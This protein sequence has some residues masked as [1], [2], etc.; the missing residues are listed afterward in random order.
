MD[1]PVSRRLLGATL[2]IIVLLSSSQARANVGRTPGAAAVTHDGE[3]SYSIP[4][5]LPPGTNG[6]TPVISLEY[7]HRTQNGLLGVGWSFGGLSQIARCPRTIVQDGI[8]SPLTLT[9][10]D[11]FC[12]DGQRLVASNGVAYGTAGAEYRTEIESFARIRAIFG[13]G[14]GPQ[15][16]VVESADGRVY[17]Y[18]ATP[19]SR[20]DGNATAIHPTVPARIWAL[21]RIRDRSGNVIDYAYTEEPTHGNF[22]VASI[23]YNSNPAAGAAPSH[24]VSFFYENRPS[25]EIDLGYI[26]GTPIRQVVRL[27]RIDILFNGS[28]LRRYDLSYEP[29]LST[30]GRSRLASIKECGAGGSACFAPTTLVWQNGTA[31][32][33]DVQAFSV[34]IPSPTSY[35]EHKLWNTL[36]I[37][38]DGR[39]DHAW[40]GG[41]TSRSATIRYRLSLAGGTWGPEIDTGILAE[42]GLGL[43]F[44]WN[45]DSRDDLLLI[46]ATRRWAILPG[47]AAGFGAQITTALNVPAQLQD[48]R[49]ADL[50]GDGLGDIAWSEL[51]DYSGNSLV[52]RAQFALPGGGFSVAPETLY[53]QA[54]AIGYEFQQGGSFMGRPGQRID[55]D[56]DGA[57]ELLLDEN[58]TVARISATSFATDFFDGGFSG[59]T[60]LDFNGDGC[61]DFAYKHQTG[62]LRVRVGGC[63]LPWSGPELQGPASNDHPNILAFDWNGDG[64]DDLLLRG[65]TTWRVALS[66]GGSVA[67]I[68]DTGIARDG[69]VSV[70]GTDVNGDGLNDFITRAPG[71]LRVRPKNGLQPD[72]LLAATDG[73]GVA[74]Q[75]TY[76]PLT[77]AGVYTRGSGATY[78]LQDMQSAAQVVSQLAV[79]DGSGDGTMLPTRFRYE[80]LR[81]HLLGRGSLGFERRKR[82]DVDAGHPLRIEEVRRQ[83][84]PFTGLPVSITV[85]QPSGKPVSISNWQW[86]VFELGNG[87]A[88]RR[89]PY[90]SSVTAQRHEVGGI[91]DGTE[92]A[93]VVRRITAIDPSSGVVTDEATTVTEAGGGV[94]AGSSASFRMQRTSLLNDTVNWCLG[95]PQGLN[96]TASHTLTGGSTITRSVS[97]NW[98]SAKCR[99][100]QARIE[101]GNSQWQLTRNFTYDAFGNLSSHGISGAGFSTRTTQLDWGSRGQ[102][103]TS[104]RNPLAQLTQL[105]WDPGTGLPVAV[106]DPN[107]LTA[108]WSYDG[109]GRPVLETQ[110]DGTSTTWTHA[111]CAADCDP[112]SRIRVTQQD[113]DSTGAIRVTANVDLDQHEREFRQAVQLPGGGV[114]ISTTV[115]NRHGQLLRQY[116][117]AWHGGQPP[118]YWQLSYDPVGRATQVT[119]H[120]ASGAIERTQSLRYEGLAVTQVDARGNTS[121]GIRTAWGKLAQVVDAAGNSTRYEYDAF[122]RLLQVRDALN[123]QV[124]AI[125]YNPRGMK[126]TQTDSDMGTWTWTRNALGEVTTLRD[127]RNQSVGY[128][129]D[130]LGRVT[131][132]L[133]PDG[134]S[135]FTWGHSA[136]QRNIGQ[137]A[138]LAGP[139]YSESFAYDAV[140]RPASRTITGDSV[141]R[142]DY[143]YNPLGLLDS[144][145][146][147]A[148]G[149][150]ARF[151]IAHEYDAGQL[152]RIFDAH[153]PATTFWRLNTVDA[154]GH[155]V[156]ESKGPVVRVMTGVDPLLGT[157]DY[158]LA[159]V[160]GTA[161]IQNLA[162]AWDANDNL[163]RRQD[164][165]RGLSEEFRYDALD[166]LDDARQNGVVNLDLSYDTIGNILWKSDV[167][168]GTTPCYAYHPTRKHA[169]TAAG[170]VSYAYDA[171]GNMTSRGGAAI[172][173][174]SDNLPIS[175]AHANGNSSQFSYGPAGNRW[176]QTANHAGTIETTIHAG[177]LSEKVT[178]AGATSWRHYVLAPTGVAAIQLR[179]GSGLNQTRYLTQDHL[180]STDKI[181]D[182]AGN[183][184][185]S[186]N[187]SPFG[188][189]RG[190]NWSGVPSAAELAVIAGVT[191]DGFTGHEHLDNLDLIHMNGRV[192]D[193]HIGRF[194]SADPYVTAPFDG[195]SLNRYSYVRNNPLTFIDPSGFTEQTPCMA[196]QQGNCAQITV[197]GLTWADYMRAFSGRVFGQTESGAERDPCGQDSNAFACAT[198]GIRLLPPSSIVLTIGTKS[199]PNLASTPTQ[200]YLQGAA[201]RLGNLAI[202]SSPLTWLF[203]A[204]PDFEWFEV[205]DSAAG[206]A[207][208]SAGDIGYLLGG[209]AGMVR[210]GGSALIGGSPSQFARSMQ[211]AGKYP[212]VDRFKDIVLKKGTILYSGHPGQTAFYTTA[213]AMRRSHGSARFLYDGLQL[214]RSRNYPIRTQMAAFSVLDDTPAAFGLAIRNGDHGA[215]W[216]PQVVVP[217]YEVSLRF[218]GVT[219]LGP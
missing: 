109:F 72:L 128:S 209:A 147:P 133:A 76:R 168:P 16:F 125:T 139:G 180:G 2:F 146:Y 150:A 28:V 198:Y 153:A 208:A 187:F 73:F 176:R 37:N 92:L 131:S 199:D 43:P 46:S 122:G 51:V 27:D 87:A 143:A 197:I 36:D 96:Q 85:R 169:V 129:Y 155:I 82:E 215:G 136:T 30:A 29:A 89:Y 75:Y 69:S 14:A 38:G 21:N 98:D 132:R 68:V 44:D 193:P 59:G 52:V 112:R 214:A 206:Q 135:Y 163:I 62:R 60:P 183:V 152:S 134:A 121:T 1:L 205:P 56:G 148:D 165:N 123:N 182:A 137:L 204:D 166:R 212:G 20:V 108:T 84:F 22:R 178:R 113:R 19:D 15:Y 42:Y 61:T 65:A 23:R 64:R 106:T 211:G 55:L 167:C 159:G 12:L 50:N 3:A 160:N 63:G 172:A 111:A 116:L 4:L 47:G 115:A 31:G 126:L 101:P 189:R 174:T 191:R 10:A 217:S 151:K 66:N 216:L 54:E 207:G 79:T 192:Y 124:A 71:Q 130:A 219:P 81:R 119:L 190:A 5:A 144:I 186:E 11:R 141:Y 175:I 117:P 35:Q 49:G 9:S 77:D 83:D 120:A 171:N 17:E 88:A 188:R 114:S 145:T 90:P 194:I 70:V 203:G 48:Y 33:G 57:E 41:A 195:Q 118:G 162:Y 201:A 185:A 25:N 127:A 34:G 91:H 94:H 202:S 67:A 78:P 138:S 210:N 6:M 53:T 26:A 58:Y 200:D 7:R 154:A 157:I 140:G 99:P 24:Q 156:D 39:S 181:L 8:A 179:S 218:L 104:I 110:P 95:R 102:F 173:W 80:G 40:I 158:R 170:G 97:L 18:G 107:A 45:G 149:S 103:L 32:Y 100:A 164:L 86:S 177:E 93:S 13:L 105:A 142:Y 74:A 161:A 196:T 213:S 184:V